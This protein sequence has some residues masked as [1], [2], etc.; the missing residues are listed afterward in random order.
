MKTSEFR[1]RFANLFRLSRGQREEQALGQCNH[2][3]TLLSGTPLARLRHK[4]RWLTYS[5]ALIEGL[6][7]R[8]AARR[9]GI[10]KNTSF[11]WR[12]RFLQ[13]PAQIKAQ[14]LQGIA[15]ADETPG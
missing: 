15:E 7:V 14:R 8:Q 2:T 3:F 12:H 5:E 9:C 10:H 4:D 13:L 1:I 11:R 6:S